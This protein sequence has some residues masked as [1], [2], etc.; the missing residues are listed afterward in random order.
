LAKG[1]LEFVGKDDKG[2]RVEILELIDHPWYIGVQFHPEYLSSVLQP[3]RPY[4][5]FMAA[6][7][8][9]LEWILKEVIA[10]DRDAASNGMVNVTLSSGIEEVAI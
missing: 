9:R 4:L 10:T 1:G 3:S 8:G 6:A 2:V 7:T 5:G